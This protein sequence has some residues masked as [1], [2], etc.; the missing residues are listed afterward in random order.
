MKGRRKQV[1]NIHKPLN[2]TK[3]LSVLWL[4]FLREQIS[5]YLVHDALVN[6]SY[7]SAKK[8]W[9][10]QKEVSLCY[11]LEISWLDI[12]SDRDVQWRDKGP[13]ATSIQSF[14]AGGSSNYLNQT[15]I[16]QLCTESTY[17]V[18]VNKSN[19]KNKMKY[20]FSFTSQKLILERFMEILL[21]LLKLQ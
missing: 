15:L 16:Y 14:W 19:W 11:K 21:T 1:I 20:C 13:V 4:M 2:L 12:S 10:G 18:L 5:W 7:I 3:M 6:T 17:S 8:S 9:V